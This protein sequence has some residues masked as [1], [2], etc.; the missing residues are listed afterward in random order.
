[1]AITREDLLAYQEVKKK[2]LQETINHKVIE[3]EEIETKVKNYKDKLVA[4]LEIKH[5]KATAT[6]N[7]EL[8]LLDDLLKKEAEQ[9]ELA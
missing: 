7:A 5:S 3:L 1:M 2:E 6:I 4:E 8:S 9:E